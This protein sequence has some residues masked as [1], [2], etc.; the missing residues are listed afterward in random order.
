MRLIRRGGEQSALVD[1]TARGDAEAA[2]QLEVLR[3]VSGRG[4]HEPTACVQRDVGGGEQRRG[5][6]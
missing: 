3:S 6:M 2:T 1:G 5:A 4:V